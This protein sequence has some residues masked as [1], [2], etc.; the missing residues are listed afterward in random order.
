MLAMQLQSPAPIDQGPLVLVEVAH[1]P[2]GPDE[3]LVAVAACAVCRTDVQLIEG[4]LPARRLPIVPGHQ[5]V[6]RVVAVGDNV[7][8]WSVGDRA[9]IGWLAG[10]CGACEFCVSG[11]ENL[12]A[13]AEFTGWDRDG[14]YGETVLGRADFALRLPD[15]PTDRELAPL[16]CGGVIGYRSLVV[17]GIQPGQRLGLFG[18]GASASLA[19]QVARHWDCEVYVVTRSESEQRRAQEL[20]AAWA[21]GYDDPMP[22][23][24]HAA[25]TFAPVGSVVVSALT[26][27]AAGGTVAINAI[28]LDRIPEFDYSLLWRERQIR[29]VANYTRTD[30]SSFLELAAEIPVRTA[31]QEY[32]LSETGAALYDVTRGTTRGTAVLVV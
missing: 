9:G 3:L 17:S 20:G 6:G 27:L 24:L 13:E 7:S 12:C 32:R 31:T 5:A 19:I 14:G 15:G 23:P 21:G 1:R 10:T 26:A 25:V 11:R 22:A 28:H 29:S 18:F 8:D 30:A 16:L 4:D 2:P